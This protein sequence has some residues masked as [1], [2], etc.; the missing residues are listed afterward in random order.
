M[1]NTAEKIRNTTRVIIGKEVNKSKHEAAESPQIDPSKNDSVTGPA[2]A[3][4]GVVN[5]QISDEEKR[6][7]TRKVKME[8]R[9]LEHR[10]QVL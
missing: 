10:V 4:S 1:S 8:R 9:S 6:Y 2:A 5:G 7:Y 3:S